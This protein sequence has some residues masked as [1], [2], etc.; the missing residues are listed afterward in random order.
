MPRSEKTFLNKNNFKSLTPQG[1]Q[2]MGIVLNPT[3]Q[4]TSTL[5]EKKRGCGVETQKRRPPRCLTLFLKRPLFFLVPKNEAPHATVCLADTKVNLRI[6]RLLAT[7]PLLNCVAFSDMVSKLF[8]RQI[9]ND[10]VF[11]PHHPEDRHF[12]LHCSHFFNHDGFVE[13][14]PKS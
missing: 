8:R 10:T 7:G 12:T 9:R 5:R 6:E 14:F 13:A 2:C 1:T 4:M 3:V 11:F